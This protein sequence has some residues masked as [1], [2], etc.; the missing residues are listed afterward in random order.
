M[1]LHVYS[2]VRVRVYD[3]AGRKDPVCDAVRA[4]GPSHVD[5]GPSRFLMTRTCRGRKKAHFMS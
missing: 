3:A 4:R 2:A 5:A 1:I